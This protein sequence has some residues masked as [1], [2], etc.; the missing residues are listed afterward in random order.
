MAKKWFENIYLWVGVVVLVIVIWLAW[1]NPVGEYDG[2]AQ[3]LTDA[4]ATM[5]GTEW[6]H[7]CKDQK[8]LFGASFKNINFVDCDR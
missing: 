1:P 4:G 2:F 6:C 3:C 8:E 5:Y 7:I